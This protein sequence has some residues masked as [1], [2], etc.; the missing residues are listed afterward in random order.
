MGLWL[1]QEN[2][3]VQGLTQTSVKTTTEADY[4]PW[5]ANVPIIGTDGAQF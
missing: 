5:A 1:G 4:N 2:V 3:R